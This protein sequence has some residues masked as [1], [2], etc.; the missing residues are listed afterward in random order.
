MFVYIL[1]FEI[2]KN[3]SAPLNIFLYTGYLLHS[4]IHHSKGAHR[5]SVA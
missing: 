4:I 1:K 5:G 2:Y 3:Q